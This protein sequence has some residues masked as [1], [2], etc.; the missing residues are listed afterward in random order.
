V[1]ATEA[2]EIAGGSRS[3]VVVVMGGRRRRFLRMARA[4]ARAEG[5]WVVGTGEWWERSVDGSDR[6]KVATEADV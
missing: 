5:G 4:V 2:S 3:A 6:R 1:K